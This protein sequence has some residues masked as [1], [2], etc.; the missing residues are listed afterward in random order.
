MSDS[1]DSQNPTQYIQEMAKL[2]LTSS[3]IS[4][5]QEKNLKYFPL[6]FFNGVS[7]A[8][9]EYDLMAKH[10]VDADED[11]VNLNIS[12]KLKLP[13]S[14]NFKVTYKLDMESDAVNENLEKRFKDLTAAIRTLFWTGITVEVFFNEESKY[15]GKT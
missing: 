15:K 3:R 13:K 8:N 5:D 9:I 7:Q 11:E 2:T 4:S 1:N 10:S 12:Y 14:N 6:I